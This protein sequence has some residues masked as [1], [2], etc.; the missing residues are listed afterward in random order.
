MNSPAS[1]ARLMSELTVSSRVLM[2]WLIGPATQVSCA[3]TIAICRQSRSDSM[4]TS[5]PLASTTG[6]PE[7]PLLTSWCTAFITSISGVNVISL[8]L[9]YSRT[10][11]FSSV[12]IVLLRSEEHPSELQSLMRISHAVLCLQKITHNNIDTTHYT[13]KLQ[14]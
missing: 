4:P 7:W 1:C 10:R 6:A 9:M 13:H 2:Y 12:A 14:N 5:L 11:T 3:A 8:E